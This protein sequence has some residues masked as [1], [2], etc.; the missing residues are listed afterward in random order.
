MRA[1]IGFIAAAVAVMVGVA[2]PAAVAGED[3]PGDDEGKGKD[4]QCLA[5]VI[6][7]E[8]GDSICVAVP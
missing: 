7:G 4:K 1:R 2:V 5:L 6:G 8:Q 3:A